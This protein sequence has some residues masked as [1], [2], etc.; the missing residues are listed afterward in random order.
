MKIILTG[1]TGFVGSNVLT[2]LV[3]APQVTEVTCLTR[4]P[5]ASDAPKVTTILHEDFAVYDPELLDRLAGHDACIWA[6]GGKAS[7]L[8]TPDVFAR[9][10]HT[11]TLALAEGVARRATTPFT[12]CYLSGMG[13]D[14]TETATF[15]WEKLT[16]HLKGRT[17]K[18]LAELQARYEQFCVHCFRPGGILPDSAN[19]LLRFLMSPI[20][21]RVGELSDAMIIGAT[22][23]SLFRQRP[24]LGN[25]DIK[26]LAREAGSTGRPQTFDARK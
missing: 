14:R 24:I 11:F 10:T 15:P 21:V 26:K 4:R 5:L 17:E 2:H 7:D 25:H 9:I 1:A 18:E 8:G 3:A 22:N 20:V 13:A 12:F 23:D 19:L 6:L 16:R